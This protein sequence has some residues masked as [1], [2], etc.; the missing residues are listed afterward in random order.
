MKEFG[1]TTLAV[2]VNPID[3]VAVPTDSN[4][5]KMRVCQYFPLKVVEWKGGKIEESIQE[6]DALDFWEAIVEGKVN[7]KDPNP[8]AIYLPKFTTEDFKKYIAD[9][10]EI[11]SKL[12]NKLI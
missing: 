10:T 1:D 4:Y 8:H 11:R 3:V 7:E 2:L 9:V 12:K 5:S 6:G